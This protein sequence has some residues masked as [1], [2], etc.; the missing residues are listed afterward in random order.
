[1]NKEYNEKRD[2]FRSFRSLNILSSEFLF[3]LLFFSYLI[4]PS[5]CLN[6]WIG[7]FV[8]KTQVQKANQRDGLS[9]VCGQTKIV[10]SYRGQIR[11]VGLSAL[12][13]DL[14]SLSFYMFPSVTCSKKSRQ[15]VGREKE[16]K[17]I[18]I[19]QSYYSAQGLTTRSSICFVGILTR[20]C[21]ARFTNGLLKNKNNKAH[22]LSH[23]RMTKWTNVPLW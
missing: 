19:L 4:Q 12:P 8:L 10:M 20:Y 14:R 2:Q 5:F 23:W 22:V 9:E 15:G 17:R 18:L 7:Y 6:I 13:C 16:R 1:M 3:W 21:T 11:S